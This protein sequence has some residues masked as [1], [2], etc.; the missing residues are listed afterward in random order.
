[1]RMLFLLPQF[2]SKHIAAAPKVFAVYRLRKRSPTT[3]GRLSRQAP[4]RYVYDVDLSPPEADDS[5]GC[6]LR[7]PEPRLI[8]VSLGASAFNL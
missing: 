6:H 4:R 7:P 3:A 2:P 5:T 1:M 8:L